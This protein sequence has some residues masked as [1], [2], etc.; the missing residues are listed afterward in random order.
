MRKILR[1]LC[2]AMLTL[3]FT[4][5]VFASGMETQ[6]LRW[7]ELQAAVEGKKVEIVLT[8]GRQ[9]EGKVLEVTPDVLRLKTGGNVTELPRATITTLAWTKIKGRWRAAGAVI[10]YAVPGG[11]LGERVQGPLILVPIG[12][13]LIGYLAGREADRK[14]VL[15]RVLP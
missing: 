8:D 1:T 5:L 6:E 4:G 10:G 13:G 3:A 14:T 2:V 12:A 7:S 9:L 11:L 15:I